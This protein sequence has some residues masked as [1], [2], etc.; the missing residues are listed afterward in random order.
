M[1]QKIKD[2]ELQNTLLTSQVKMLKA[3]AVKDLGTV[4]DIHKELFR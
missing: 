2:L 3:Q 1:K 4:K